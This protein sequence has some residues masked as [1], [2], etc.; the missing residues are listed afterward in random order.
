MSRKLA[1]A[2]AVILSLIVMMTSAGVAFAQEDSEAAS[3][4]PA[5]AV[6]APRTVAIGEAVRIAVTDL[7]AGNPVSGVEVWAWRWPL[8]RPL[9]TDAQ[10]I[11]PPGWHHQFLGTTGDDGKVTP[12][13]AFEDAGRFLIIATHSGYAPGLHIIVVKPKA[14]AVEAPEKAAVGEPVTIR[15]VDRGDGEPVAEARVYALRQQA[16][17][18]ALGKGLLRKLRDFGNNLL[19][20]RGALKNNPLL[21]SGPLPSAEDE[22]GASLE[23]LAVNRGQDLG[24]TDENGELVHAFDSPGRYRIVAVKQG[25]IPGAAHMVVRSQNAVNALTIKGPRSAEIDEAVTFTVLERGADSVVE[26]ADVYALRRPLRWGVLGS[27][28]PFALEPPTLDGA[29]APLE[30]LAMQY[31][32]YLGKTDENGEV[33]HAFGE[34]GRYLVVATKDGYIPG[35]THISIGKGRVLPLPK[36]GAENDSRRGLRLGPRWPLP[37]GNR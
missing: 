29:G 27:E 31:G 23:D 22:T 34:G 10:S 12:A 5:L 25:Y 28:R 35:I 24:Q 3:Q 33:T 16:G 18:G 21:P 9:A 19:Q 4:V 1:C 6:T 36:H 37:W 2:L 15:V 20:R 14:L 13:P 8:V 11:V 17:W 7:N 26:G 30:A 32:E